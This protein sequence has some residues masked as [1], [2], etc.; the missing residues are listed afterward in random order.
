MDGGISKRPCGL[1]SDH[2]IYRSNTDHDC[3]LVQACKILSASHEQISQFRPG[4][5]PRMLQHKFDGIPASTL[6]VVDLDAAIQGRTDRV[7]PT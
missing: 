1:V 5:A 4:I 2:R 7:S 3:V 6:A